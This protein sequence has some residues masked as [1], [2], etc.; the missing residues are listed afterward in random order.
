MQ[1]KFRTAKFI[2]LCHSF[3]KMYVKTQLGPQIKRRLTEIKVKK[4]H[5]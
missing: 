3:Q 1:R 2:E 4:I 5:T